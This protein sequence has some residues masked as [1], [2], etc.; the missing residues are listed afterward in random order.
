MNRANPHSN[1]CTIG[2]FNCA[3]R[4]LLAFFCILFVFNPVVAFA[5]EQGLV[6]I[7]ISTSPLSAPFIIAHEQGYFNE[8]GVDV[9][10]KQVK[11]G[12]LA[13]DMVLAG[14]A[15]IA[16]SSEAVVMFNS[17]KR[18]DF[19]LFCTFVTSDNDVKILAR[20][21]SGIKKIEDL[22]G[23]NVGTI[24]GASAHFFLSHTLLMN[25]V[26][27]KDV[28]ISAI[29]PEEAKQA[30]DEHKLDAVVT[31]EPYAYLA[32]KYL[33][34][35]VV[36]VEHEQVYIETFNAITRKDYANKNLLKLG[37]ITKVLIKATQFINANPEQTQQIVA[38]ALH[39][40]LDVV[41]NSW[42]DFSFSV[43][44]SQWLLTSM[45]TEARW[46][47]EHGFLTAK[48]MPDYNDFINTGPLKNTDPKRITI[49]N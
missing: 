41:K 10:I 37:L 17:F 7:A 39:K 12:H 5:K 9:D 49:Y 4:W 25:G 27:E 23:K 35:R 36:L 28:H 30:L 14:S 26:A 24:L 1:A 46:A 40:D 22:K 45:E 42:K 32:H 21:D 11:G 2:Y 3:Q 44:L 6:R 19:S 34:D 38:K 48:E 15:D 13:L 47:I 43:G 18:N 29:K 8:L 16:T 31:W 20:K 33:G